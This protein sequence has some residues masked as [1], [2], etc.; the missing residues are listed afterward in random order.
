MA[1]LGFLRS[2]YI[3]KR[4]GIGMA[5]KKRGTIGINEVAQEESFRDD[6]HF[7]GSV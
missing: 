1:W 2:I 4:A 5:S 6:I 7:N 3:F